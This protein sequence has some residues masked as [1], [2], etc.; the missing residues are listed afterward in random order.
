MEITLNRV[1][2]AFPKFFTAEDFKGDGNFKFSSK[3]IVEDDANTKLIDDTV[4]AVAKE[5]WKGKAEVKMKQV[6]AKDKLCFRDGD[7]VDLDGCAGNMVMSATRKKAD[8]APAVYDR[9][10]KERLTEDDGVIYSGCYM[11]V[12]VEIWAMDND[13][14]VG[15]NAALVAGQFAGKGES[16][17]GKTRSA[18]AGEFGDLGVDPDAEAPWEEEESSDLA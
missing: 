12:K 15:I 10:G 9:S 16:F 11:N 2:V 1:R 8:G 13:F 6:V 18:S 7:L 3:L 4:K 5:K 17:G 14:G